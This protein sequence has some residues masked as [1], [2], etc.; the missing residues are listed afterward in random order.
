[1]GERSLKLI[2]KNIIHWSFSCFIKN[3]LEDVSI[4]IDPIKVT[5]CTVL[6]LLRREESYA[7]PVRFRLLV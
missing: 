6:A 3:I 2:Y 7:S 4:L 5:K 1:M